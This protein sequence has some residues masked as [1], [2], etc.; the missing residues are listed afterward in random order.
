MVT[1]FLPQPADW[2]PGPVA[3]PWEHLSLVEDVSLPCYSLCPE[4][5]SPLCLP[6]RTPAFFPSN[7]NVPSPGK[8]SLTAHRMHSSVRADLTSHCDS[9]FNDIK[10]FIETQ[11]PGA[12]KQRRTLS[13]MF[14]DQSKWRILKACLGDV[15][16]AGETPLP[17]LSAPQASVNDRNTSLPHPSPALPRPSRR[18]RWELSF[19]LP[20]LP[21]GR[22]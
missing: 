13:K 19:A 3:G 1:Q 14:V 9:P 7:P 8:L 2:S 20:S 12:Q 11:S 22:W 21:G 15:L 5:P 4:T 17:G 10:L 18:F 6:R 16:Q